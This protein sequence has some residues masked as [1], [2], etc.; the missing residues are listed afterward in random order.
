[1]DTGD[2]NEPGGEAQTFDEPGDVV[3]V[4]ASD[5]VATIV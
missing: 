2:M 3:I 4:E 5:G 1:M